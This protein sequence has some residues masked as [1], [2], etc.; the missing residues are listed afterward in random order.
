[1]ALVVIS[2]TT[3]I[4][5]PTAGGESV[6]F[7]CRKPSAPEVSKFLSGRY[8]RKRNKMED[9]RVE[10]Q[11]AFAKSILLDVENL[12]YEL[13]GTNG[14]GTGKV[15]GLNKSTVLTE[16]DKHFYGVSDWKDVIQANWLVSV[17]MQF[18][19]AS[20]TGLD[21]EEDEDPAKN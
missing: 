17:A 5:I 21:G 19:E 16:E 1:M 4:K 11:V 2:S 18:E 9:R 6:T 7:I 10:A 15:V 14:I 20:V 3:R 13:I 12:G 8:T